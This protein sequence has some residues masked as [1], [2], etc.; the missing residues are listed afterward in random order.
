MTIYADCVTRY[1]RWCAERDHVPMSRRALNKC[2]AGMLDAGAAPRDRP[3][4]A[5]DRA[6][7]RLLAH[8]R[9]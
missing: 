3:D 1:L 7:L 6:L 5:I 2:V 4:P 9:R 8:R